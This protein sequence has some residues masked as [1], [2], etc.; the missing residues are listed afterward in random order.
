MSKIASNDLLQQMLKMQKEFQEQT[1]FQPTIP[2]LAS[3]IM[4]E[5]GELWGATG[6]WWKKKKKS[7]EEI[8]G[9]TIDIFHFLLA[10]WLELDLDA[11]QIFKVYSQKLGINY[12]RQKDGY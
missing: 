8:A 7:K 6:K 5:G 1:G 3:A 10:V 11:E 12:Q 4:A 2:Q 9:E